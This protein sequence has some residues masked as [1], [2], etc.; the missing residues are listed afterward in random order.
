M[1]ARLNRRSFMARVVGASAL[2]GGALS[3]ILGRSFAQTPL[4]RSCLTDTD[5]TD[6]PDYGTRTGLTDSDTTDRAERGTLTRHSDSD[7]H[8]LANRGRSWRCATRTG[9]TD[10]DSGA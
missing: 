9:V 2:G 3:L 5:S 10:R 8:D 4:S 1:P 7:A 6:R